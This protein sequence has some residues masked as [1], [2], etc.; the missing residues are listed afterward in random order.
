MGSAAQLE[1]G[2]DT[3]EARSVSSVRM[4]A[5]S[6][7]ATPSPT[8]TSVAVVDEATMLEL[9]GIIGGLCPENRRGTVQKIKGAVNSLVSAFVDGFDAVAT[10]TSAAVAHRAEGL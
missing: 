7:V 2:S 3:P 5:S 8:S 1:G 6:E 4:V 9:K 10:Q